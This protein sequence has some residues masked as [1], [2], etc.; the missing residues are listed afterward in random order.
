MCVNHFSARLTSYSRVACAQRPGVG[1][2][3]PH[4]EVGRTGHEARVSGSLMP[5][6]LSVI[7]PATHRGDILARRLIGTRRMT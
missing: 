7:V 5:T 3:E 6:L 4:T 2:R 1:G